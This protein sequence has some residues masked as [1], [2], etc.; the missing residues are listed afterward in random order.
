MLLKNVNV[1]LSGQ[2]YL[3]VKQ[4]L[5]QIYNGTYFTY[6]KIQ[7]DILKT[8]VVIKVQSI[9]SLIQKSTGQNIAVWLLG[10]R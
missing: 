8:S 5:S 6:S 10:V 4:I 7:N 2:G 3:K 9:L 1:K